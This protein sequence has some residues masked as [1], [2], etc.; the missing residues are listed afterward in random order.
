[1]AS[2][3]RAILLGKRKPEDEPFLR[4]HNKDKETTT[5]GFADSL[6][7]NQVRV[8]FLEKKKSDETNLVVAKVYIT[9]V[10]KL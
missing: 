8:K 10:G 4:K 9:F 6:Q 5:E 7:Q 3:G 1:M 2:S